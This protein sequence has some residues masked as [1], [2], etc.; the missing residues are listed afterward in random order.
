M[1]NGAKVPMEKV[2]GATRVNSKLA[3]SPHHPPQVP[4]PVCT[5]TVMESAYY[6]YVP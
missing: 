1:A 6:Y 4:T 5:A 2:K 3:A